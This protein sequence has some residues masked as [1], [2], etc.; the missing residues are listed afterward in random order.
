[1]DRSILD[2]LDRTFSI[3]RFPE[4]IKDSTQ[5]SFANGNRDRRPEVDA[6]HA[7]RQTVRASQ[8]D[9][10]NPAPRQ[11]LLNLARETN[12]NV[13][14]LVFYSHSVV[15]GGQATVGKLGVERRSDDLRYSANVLIRIGLVHKLVATLRA[16]RT[17]VPNRALGSFEISVLASVNNY[18]KNG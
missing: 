6:L 3:D 15:D 2:R 14:K 9:A 16:G 17:P 4:Q 13:A 7:S 18:G 11:V 10:T 8:R 5:R 1:M 12:F